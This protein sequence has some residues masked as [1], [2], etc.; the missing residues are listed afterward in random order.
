MS[1]DHIP[2]SAIARLDKATATKAMQ[3]LLGICSGLMADA[4]LNDKEISYLQLWLMENQSIINQW[5]AN[6]IAN[7]ITQI[8]ADGIITDDE[9]SGLIEL[10]SEVSGN[11]FHET[12]AASPEGPVLPLNSAPNIFFRNTVFCFTGE[13]IFGNRANCEEAVLSLGSMISDR[14]TRKLNYL[15]I[16]TRISPSWVNTTYG[17]KIESAVDYQAKGIDIQIISEQ[18]WL[19]AI[20]E[21]AK[22]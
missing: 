8:K 13:F 22:D 3:E 5:P 2:P 6:A 18:Q 14:V 19:A 4:V 21:V 1:A 10:L 7:R 17:R 20:S 11:Y 9:R 15:V 12:G 16:G